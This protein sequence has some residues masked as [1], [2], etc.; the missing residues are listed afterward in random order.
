M[1]RPWLGP[2][3]VVALASHLAGC[4]LMFMDKTPDNVPPG[5]WVEC[6]ESRVF[7]GIDTVMGVTMLIGSVGI[8]TAADEGTETEEDAARVAAPIYGIAGIALLYSAYVGFRESNQCEQVHQDA[9]ARGMYGPQPYYP[10]P[11]PQPYPPQ[12]YPPPQPQPQPQP[13]PPPAQPTPPPPPPQ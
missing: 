4:S 7:P 1:G 12:P 9:R 10:Q 8:A 2:V 6:T 3:A 13:Q 5:A 11:Y